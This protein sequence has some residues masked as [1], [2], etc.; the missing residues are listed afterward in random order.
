VRSL[1]GRGGAV[2]VTVSPARLRP[3]DEL[4]A[5][6]VVP[7]AI[8]KVAAA[9]AELGYVN[10]YAYRWAG[11][12]DAAATA[13]ADSL[14][15][16]GQVGTDYG[17]ERETTDWVGVV[18]TPLAIRDGALAAGTR[19]LPFRVPSWAP[20]SSEELVTWAVRLTVDRKGRD[21][22]ADGAFVVLAPAPPA[23]QQ[24]GPA[25]H[26]RVMGGSSDIAIHLD[27][28][29]WRAGETMSGTVV[30]TAP[31]EGLP[32]ADVAVVLQYDRLSHPLERTPA[33][34]VTFDRGLVSIDKHVALAAGGATELPF[35]LPLPADA[36]PTAEAVHSSLE[37]FVLVRIL[38]KG[39]SA[40]LPER[41]RLG[42]VVYND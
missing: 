33:R 4:S 13:G 15:T 35:A 31:A 38:Y 34:A 37:W 1:F 10:T 2:A 42:F 16:I 22:E 7:S 30:I 20:A 11:R 3:G 27:R 19:D 41:V 9:K 25:R 5:T 14:A 6:I 29:A 17:S 24:P 39:F 40:H 21:I 26:E 36:G 28:P 32:E 23:G 8:E 12:A 18:E